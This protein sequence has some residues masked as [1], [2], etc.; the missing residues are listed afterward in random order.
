MLCVVLV[1]WRCR[2]AAASL[3]LLCSALRREFV[4]EREGIVPGGELRVTAFVC[5][6]K[7]QPSAAVVRG[8]HAAGVELVQCTDK[9]EDA[10]RKL[11]RRLLEC[12][13]DLAST[14][15]SSS[16]SSSS[17]S[18]AEHTSIVIVSSDVDFAED[19][20][21]LS[22]RGFRVVALHDARSPKQR[23][24]LSLHVAAAYEVGAVT[25]LP[26]RACVR[27]RCHEEGL[28]SLCDS[29]DA[30]SSWTEPTT[31][32]EPESACEV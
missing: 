3:L 10:D 16:S 22:A 25:V 20:E 14:E 6:S 7:A 26:R 23:A 21:R 9:R 5:P 28:S 19:A 12:E 1:V 17:S 30:P 24:A 18:A 13:R 27:S 11:K 2:S 8:L 29:E 31:S 4:R 15:S 32:D